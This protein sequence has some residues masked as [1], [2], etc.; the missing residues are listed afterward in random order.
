MAFVAILR[1]ATKGLLQTGKQS[2][3]SVFYD[4]DRI[5]NNVLHITRF[6]LAGRRQ[7]AVRLPPRLIPF[8]L[9]F[10]SPRVGSQPRT[11]DAAMADLLF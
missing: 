4:P 6:H 11:P 10:S 8:L 3:P 7:R 1:S 2:Q 9:H 5:D